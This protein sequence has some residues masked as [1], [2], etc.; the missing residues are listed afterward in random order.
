MSGGHF[1]FHDYFDHSLRHPDLDPY[2]YLA[3]ER[4]SGPGAIWERDVERIVPEL[5]V[6][7]FDLL[8]IDGR[9]WELLPPEAE[10]KTVIHLIQDFRHGD[11]DD[12]RF[13]FLLRAAVRICISP[14][15]ANVI[16]PH[17]NGP[18]VVI[19][20]GIDTKLF[21]PGEKEPGSVLVWARK[22]RALGK[23]I[24]SA[25]R[26]R[27]ANVR[28]LT[29]PIARDEFARLLATVEIFVGL[30]KAREGFFLPALEA[31]TSGCAVV[32]ADATGNR[33]YCVDGETCR[34]ASFGDLDDHVRL[35]EEVRSDRQQL[36]ALRARGIEVARAYT[37]EREQATF[38]HV[39]EEHALKKS[40]A[41]T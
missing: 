22:D 15:L 9:D 41:T 38:H 27:G 17:A 20:N 12:P 6:E 39:I 23:S 14:E 33:S 30:T 5:D 19:P 31:M 16:R 21:A 8:F 26:D 34:I 40:A 4:T 36:D 18:V 13:A 32:C 2:V 11:A 1:K 37:L 25:L 3:Y 28:L 24:R 7:S 35:A 29:R 10:R